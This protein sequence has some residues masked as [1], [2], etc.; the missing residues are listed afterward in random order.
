MAP[1]N[2]KVPPDCTFRP[3]PALVNG[4]IPRVKVPPLATVIVPL[5]VKAVL[6]YPKRFRRLAPLVL[7]LPLFTKFAGMMLED[8]P[9]PLATSVPLLVTDPL[10]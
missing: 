4:V 3:V 9:A 8:A 1:F 6:L 7:M 2:V 5:L 10:P